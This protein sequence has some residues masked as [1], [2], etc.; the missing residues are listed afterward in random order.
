MDTGDV[1]K[2][3]IKA[4]RKLFG[5]LSRKIRC[6]PVMQ[7]MKL[8]PRERFVPA[9]SRH[10]SY[11]DVPLAIG[12]GQTI[13]QPFIVALMIK[14][15]RLLGHERVLEVG[16][17]SGYQAAILSLLVPQ[18]KVVAVELIPLL[19]DGAEKLL[20]QLEYANVEVKLAG[21]ELGCAERGPFDAIIV[22][23]ASPKLPEALLSQLAVGGRLIIPVGT[24]EQQ[25]LVFVS[26]TDEGL[27]VR[28]LGPCRFVPLI[29]R[30]AFPDG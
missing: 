8:V 12:E 20:K 21:P 24:L 9:E 16:A 29:G 23:A 28:M 19:A 13:S 30:E 2:S 5:S 1:N 26:R 6:E 25:E 18:G 17:G 11:Q 14:E 3:L 22:S 15:L 4:K 7:A 27:S 10:L